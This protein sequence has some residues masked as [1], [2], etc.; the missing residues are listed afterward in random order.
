MHLPLSRYPGWPL[1]D[2]V[3]PHPSQ[4]TRLLSAV[5]VYQNIRCTICLVLFLRCHWVQ[6]MQPFHIKSFHMTGRPDNT[7]LV[8][9]PAVWRSE[10]YSAYTPN[11]NAGYLN[12]SPRFRQFTPGQNYMIL[13]DPWTTAH[14]WPYV[15]TKGPI[16]MGSW[17]MDELRTSCKFIVLQSQPAIKLKSMQNV[18]SVIYTPRAWNTWPCIWRLVGIF[19]FGEGG[20]FVTPSFHFLL[21]SHR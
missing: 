17:H 5:G 2:L 6:S 11:D 3:P 16:N 12:E 8:G 7:V 14:S 4:R 21:P 1:W 13:S 19:Q 9:Q 18:R 10:L 20:Q 15:R